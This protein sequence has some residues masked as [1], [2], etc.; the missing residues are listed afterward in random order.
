M[1]TFPRISYQPPTIH[2]SPLML[3]IEIS[4]S[5]WLR[6]IIFPSCEFRTWRQVSLNRPAA[7]SS[8][9]YLQ[10]ARIVVFLPLSSLSL[11]RSIVLPTA[12][13]NQDKGLLSKDVNEGAASSV[14][15]FWQAQRLSPTRFRG[16]VY[17]FKSRDYYRGTWST[18]LSKAKKGVGWARAVILQSQN[19]H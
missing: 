9:L 11:R 8:S 10:S 13:I 12:W 19:A 3:L 17:C 15:R 4:I 7:F 6:G 5:N 1:S 18:Q 16:T 14:R 2:T